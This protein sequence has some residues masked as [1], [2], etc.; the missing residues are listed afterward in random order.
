VT[1]CNH[2]TMLL[3]D[4]PAAAEENHRA[5]EKFATAMAQSVFGLRCWRL[6]APRTEQQSPTAHRARYRGNSITALLQLRCTIIPVTA[7]LASATSIV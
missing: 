3:G 2:T 1:P 7:M 5:R 4:L 6:G